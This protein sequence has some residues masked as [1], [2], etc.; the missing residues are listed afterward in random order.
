TNTPWASSSL[1]RLQY[2]NLFS[3]TSEMQEVIDK[4]LY[5]YLSEII[6]LLCEEKLSSVN[7]INSFIDNTG[8]SERCSKK[9]P[10]CN[11]LDIDNRKQ[12]CPKCRTRLPTLAELQKQH[13]NASA[14][15]EGTPDRL[16]IYKPYN[17]NKKTEPSRSSRISITQRRSADR[18]VNIPDIFVPD[19]LNVNPNSTANVEKVLLHIEKISG[20]KDGIRK[21]MAV[22]CDG[23]PYH[24]ISKIRG[25]YPWLILIP[26]QL[27]E[28]MN[29]LRAYVEL[30]W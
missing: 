16:T 28:E 23:I 1:N 15:A 11:E 12:V 18:G 5:T 19:P 10:S 27:H 22:A 6:E 20:I 26:G 21:W 9:C 2:E 25:K 13:A 24:R 29:M 14:L 8:S 7:N 30:N 3:I 17:V 4:E